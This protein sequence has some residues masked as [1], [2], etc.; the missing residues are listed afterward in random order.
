MKI[1]ALACAVIATTLALAGATLAIDSASAAA[2]PNAVT[3]ISPVTTTPIGTGYQLTLQGTWAV[4]DNSAA[5]DTFALQLPSQ[6]QWFGPVDFSLKD[7]SGDIVATGHAAADGSVVFTLSD[8]VTDHPTDVH[9][10]FTFVTTYTATQTQPGP[11]TLN[12]TV[13][14]TVVAVPIQDAGPGTDTGPN[15]PPTSISQAFKWA[16]WSDS[17][18]Q[19]RVDSILSTPTLTAPATVVTITDTPAAG[20]ELDC[21]SIGTAVG[22]VLDT[23]WRVDNGLAATHAADISCDKTLATVTWHDLPAGATAQLTISAN[24][25]DSSQTSFTNDGAI[26]IDQASSPVS[27]TVAYEG[28]SGEGSGSGEVVSPPSPTPTLTPT[29]TPTPVSTPVPTP[30][31]T[32]ASVPVKGPGSTGSRLAFT[33]T[34]PGILIQVGILFLVL[35]AIFVVV[36]VLRRRAAAGI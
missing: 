35:G 23:G 15:T 36:A 13:G 29:A 3:N 26:V 19:N 27:S 10:T 2:I 4:P 32:I 18:T 20:L 33:G 24:V 8:Y 30:A 7:S 25:T 21:S 17:S 11:E 14:G 22:T 9:G 6:L 31:P 34:D 28:A 16:W 1:R 12:F 5:G